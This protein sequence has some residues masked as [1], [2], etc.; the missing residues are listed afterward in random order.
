MIRVSSGKKESS[1]ATS[2]DDA[3]FGVWMKKPTVDQDLFLP[4]L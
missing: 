3:V 4:L 1:L 2:V